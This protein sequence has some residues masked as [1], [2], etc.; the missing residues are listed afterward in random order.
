MRTKSSPRDAGL[1]DPPLRP[2]IAVANGLSSLPAS[3]ALDF[4]AAS[5][6]TTGFSR[7]AQQKCQGAALL[8]ERPRLWTLCGRRI[9]IVFPCL[10]KPS[11]V[12]GDDRRVSRAIP[13]IADLLNH[14]AVALRVMRPPRIEPAPSHVG[15]RPVTNQ[16]CIPPAR[17]ITSPVAS[18]V[19]KFTFSAS[20]RFTAVRPG[21]PP[22]ASAW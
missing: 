16:N 8:S 21:A 22:Q 10:A 7:T 4:I 6:H 5:P 20:F 9:K 14:G 13:A 15:A 19:D 2:A 3:L 12:V 18:A 1:S 11:P 17:T